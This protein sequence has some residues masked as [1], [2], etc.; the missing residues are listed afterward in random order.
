MF[1]NFVLITK[2]RCTVEDFFNFIRYGYRIETFNKTCFRLQFDVT[3]I[4]MCYVK[5]RIQEHDRPVDN[6][7]VFTPN[8]K[9]DII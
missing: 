4:D 8:K 3:N 1:V 6:L 7:R 9:Y 2:L 5:I